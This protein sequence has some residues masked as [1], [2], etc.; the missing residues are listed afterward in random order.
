[1]TWCNK[2]GI[3]YLFNDALV[4]FLSILI[5]CSILYEHFCLYLLHCTWLR[6]IRS[7]TEDLIHGF[8]AN[9]WLVHNWFMG[10]GNPLEVVVHY[11]LIGGMIGLGYRDGFPMV[12]ALVCLVTHWTRP[13]DYYQ[14]VLFCRPNNNG[15]KHL[16]VVIIFI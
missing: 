14:K 16:W 7:C 2:F 15:F 6:C 8:I 11:L 10:L 9:R 13:I 12:S 3:R 4:S 1:M 5:P